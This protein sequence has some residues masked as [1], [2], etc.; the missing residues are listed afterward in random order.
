MTEDDVLIHAYGSDIF[1]KW[2][3]FRYHFEH[4]LRSGSHTFARSIVRACLDCERH[5]PGFAKGMIDALAAQSGREK[6]RR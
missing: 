6:D 2:H 5:I 1:K 3:W 4:H